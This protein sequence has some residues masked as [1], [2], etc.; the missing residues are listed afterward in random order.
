MKHY[1]SLCLALTQGDPCGIGPEII[2]RALPDLLGFPAC[3]F[4]L[5]GDPGVFQEAARRFAP[6]SERKFWEKMPVH[7]GEKPVNDFQVLLLSTGQL[8]SPW[9]R[10]GRPGPAEGRA[11]AAAIARSAGLCLAGAA[12][13]LVT[14]PITKSAMLAGGSPFG[15]HTELLA[16]LTGVSHPVMMLQND[17]L[18]VLLVTTHL[19]LAEVPGRLNSSA[20]LRLLQTAHR[21][22]QQ[23]FGI[24]KPRFLVAGLNPHAGEGGKLGTE[25][26]KIIAPAIAKA[27]REG[28][29]AEGPFPP[30]SLFARALREKADAVVCMYHDQGLIPLKMLDF[31][32][33][34]N[35]TLGLPIVR[36]SVGHGAAPDIAWQGK[37][38]TQSLLRAAELALQIAKRR[39]GVRISRQ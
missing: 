16:A 33:T 22:L 32:N 1:P 36:T 2:V 35:V 34:V 5:I 19:P 25:E 38:S 7:D 14:A 6:R 18:R 28:I 4:I 30:D 26:K 31:E 23:D 13:A 24:R 11:M 15:G 29:C 9:L 17:R 3:R 20:I 10:P 8:D 37:A 39:K 12:D 27:R 21:S